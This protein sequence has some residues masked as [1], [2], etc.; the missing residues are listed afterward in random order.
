MKFINQSLYNTSRPY[1]Y[2]SSLFSS[3]LHSTYMNDTGKHIVS[4]S[5]TVSVIHLQELAI[6]NQIHQWQPQKIRNQCSSKHFSKHNIT[7]S[8]TVLVIHLQE[9]SIYN[10]IHHCGKIWANKKSMLI[11]NT[12]LYSRGIGQ[13]LEMLFPSTLYLE[14]GTVLKT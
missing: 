6:Y 4:L 9:L 2:I 14:L 8:T 3:V 11:S 13:W 1:I 7:L 5:S 12:F 10:Q